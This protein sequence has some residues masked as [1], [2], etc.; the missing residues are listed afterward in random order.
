MKIIKYDATFRLEAIKLA[1]QGK[2]YEEISILLGIHRNTLIAWR[3]RDDNF[4]KI[5]QEARQQGMEH[6][7]VSGLV[8]LAQGVKREEI[9]DEYIIEDAEGQPIKRRVKT[10]T[11]A[12]QAKAIEML[13]RRH[14][15]E[16]T[17]STDIDIVHNTLNV[18]DTSAMSLREVQAM[19][20]QS[21]IEAECQES[22]D[23]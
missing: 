1:A 3:K 12:P 16:Y 22:D 10:T 14:A 5:M 18:T 6:I 19:L 2:T 21:P 9:T 7:I 23:E 20:R 11:D 8:K 15:K 13:A 17:D 4:N